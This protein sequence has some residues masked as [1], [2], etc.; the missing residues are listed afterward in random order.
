MT[1][2]PV[3]P[4]VCE[5]PCCGCLVVSWCLSTWEMLWAFTLHTVSKHGQMTSGVKG[6]LTIAVQGKAAN[7]PQNDLN[8]ECHSMHLESRHLGGWGRRIASFSLSWITRVC[9][10]I[11]T[12]RQ[13]QEKKGKSTPGF[14]RFGSFHFKRFY[15]SPDF[16]SW[17]TDLT[18]YCEAP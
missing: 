17:P 8:A 18:V 7:F 11:R 12:G 14:K 6:Q 16:A 1:E 15:N 4:N 5:L 3:V 9:L 13:I 2:E 10:K